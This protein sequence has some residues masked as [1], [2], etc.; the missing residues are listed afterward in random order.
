MATEAGFKPIFGSSGSESWYLGNPKHEML[1]I[2]RLSLLEVIAISMVNSNYVSHGNYTVPVQNSGIEQ[3]PLHSSQGTYGSQRLAHPVWNKYQKHGCRR[4]ARLPGEPD[5]FPLATGRVRPDVGDN[6]SHPLTSPS[7]AQP[8]VHQ[9]TGLE[10][11][12]DLIECIW[13]TTTSTSTSA[14][15]ISHHP[16]CTKA[17]S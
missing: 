16:S 15:A 2:L 7:P 17:Q 10:R 13:R 1:S 3:I 14:S 6:H 5:S 4:D 12:R 8:N 9:R 11:C